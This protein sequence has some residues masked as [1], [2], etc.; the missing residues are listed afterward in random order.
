MVS[1]K[2]K[3]VCL[4]KICRL[5][6][7]SRPIADQLQPNFY[8]LPCVEQR[9]TKLDWKITIYTVVKCPWIFIFIF[10]CRIFSWFL[11]IFV[12]IIHIRYWQILLIIT[13]TIW[14]ILH[15]ATSSFKC[16]GS[17][18]AVL[19]YFLLIIIINLFILFLLSIGS[20]FKYFGAPV[21]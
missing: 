5:K 2:S 15:T 21:L 8:K 1:K 7:I 14:K 12:C 13:G 9:I 3:I 17:T 11:I 18:A 6:F 20:I 16:W 19:F 4:V 10:L